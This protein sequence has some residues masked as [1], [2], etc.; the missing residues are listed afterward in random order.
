[1]ELLAATTCISAKQWHAHTVS[2][3]LAV[4]NKPLQK[5]DMANRNTSLQMGIGEHSKSSADDVMEHQR[6]PNVA[7]SRATEIW[8]QLKAK[9]S[10][11]IFA[12][13]V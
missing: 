12:S 5:R 2:Y 10:N 8:Y 7:V 13:L 9:P 4:N 6:V 3:Q 11:S 1:M